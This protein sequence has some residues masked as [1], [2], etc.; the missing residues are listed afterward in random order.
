MIMLENF[1]MLAR[2]KAILGSARQKLLPAQ[3][4]IL[5]DC[6]PI[7]F[8]HHCLPYLPWNGFRLAVNRIPVANYKQQYFVVS[9]KF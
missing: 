7:G 3:G 2:I 1:E 9:K 4:S 8:G 6:Q 5:R